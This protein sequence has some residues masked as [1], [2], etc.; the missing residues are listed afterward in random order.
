MRVLNVITTPFDF[1]GITNVVLNYYRN[2][3]KSN[4]KID[5]VVFKSNREDL[6]TEIELNGSNVF[7]LTNRKR[8]PL[9][10]IKELLHIM[11]RGY[12]AIHVHGNSSTMIIEMILAK[13]KN[14]NGRIAHCHNST[15]SFKI[16]NRILKPLFNKSYTDAAA[17]SKLAGDWLFGED[18][19]IIFNNA[20]NLEY[21]KYNENIRNRY[22]EKLHLTDKFVVGHVGHFTEQKNHSFL[23]DIFN[24][25][26]KKNNNAVLLLISDGKLRN[27]I[28]IKIKLLG[29]EDKVILLGKRTDIS[30]LMQA[31]DVFI[32]PSKWEGLGM[33][34]IEAQATGLRCFASEEVPKEAKLTDLLH[35][36][37]LD[38][39]PQIWGNRILSETQN[40]D[41][42]NDKFNRQIRNKKYDI[43][44]EASKL[45]KLYLK[46]E[47]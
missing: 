17:C 15:C 38:E 19:Y 39:S 31:M 37:S 16:I 12:D 43:K 21:Y 29:L 3:D 40:I 22:R 45:K 8:K 35:Y 10:Y 42:S 30:E 27:Q 28:E 25:I 34:L 5:F 18:N 13:K 2:M 9:K 46:Y 14:I 11:D 1:N 20:V 4:I 7:E 32:F 24:E 23:L 36:I 6:K 26:Y 41:R 44:Y 33:V 47:N